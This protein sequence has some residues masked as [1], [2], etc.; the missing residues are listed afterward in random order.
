MSNNSA[1]KIDSLTRLRIEK[2]K[3]ATFCTY[4]EKLIG[5][6]IDYF[7]NNYSEVLSDSILPYDRA[8]NKFTNNL[9]DAVNN[10]IAIMLPEVFKGKFLPGILL[11]MVEILSIWT[12]RQSKG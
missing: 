3:L 11:K 6:K 9:L 5:L 1:P 12:F 2:N 7:R 8:Q 4:Q 10:I